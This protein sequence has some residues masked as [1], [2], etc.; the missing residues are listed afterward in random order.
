MNVQSE[1]VYTAL[2]II[3]QSEIQLMSCRFTIFLQLYNCSW[4]NEHDKMEHTNHTH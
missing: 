2:L 3:A 4:W 1:S